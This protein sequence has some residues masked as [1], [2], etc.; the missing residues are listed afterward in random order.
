M[1]ESDVLKE[2]RGFIAERLILD[3]LKKGIEFPPLKAVR[4]EIEPHNWE[5]IS[6][7]SQYR[8][9]LGVDFVWQ[10]KEYK[11][12]AEVK[13]QS[14]PKAL[15]DAIRQIQNYVWEMFP[16]NVGRKYYPMVVVPYLSS[17]ALERLI[18]SNISGFDLSGNGVIIVPGGWFVY[19][20]GAKNRFPTSTTI[21]N[22][23][24]G[25]SSLVARVLLMRPQFNSVNEV[26][27]EIRRR[28]GEITLP[29][30]SKALKVLGEELIVGREEGVRLLDA[31]RL[32]ELLE[33]NYRRPVVRRRLRGKLSDWQA[34]LGHMLLNAQE[35]K[36]KLVGEDV[37]RYAVMPS[38]G[39][40]LSVYTSSIETALRGVGFTESSRFWDVELLET[41]EPTIYFDRRR[42]EN[43]YWMSP[44]EVYLGL[45]AGGKRERETAEQMLEEIKEFRYFL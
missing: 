33:R 37:T 3:E 36:V 38:A 7:K 24:R 34:D 6:S 10:D 41:D 31:S 39:R 5:S 29:T 22:V 11:F 8:P 42:A 2:N 9:D 14:T 21:K 1:R 40:N 23:F 4:V 27:E 28:E 25:T 17:E 30:V 32:L 16:Q 20:T 19:R 45:R 43:F 18:E 15:D 35:Q 13:R 12:I 44:I 26:Y